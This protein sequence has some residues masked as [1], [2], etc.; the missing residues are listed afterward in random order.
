MQDTGSLLLDHVDMRLVT[1]DLGDASLDRNAIVQLDPEHPGFRDADY[2]ARRNR[3]A[4][5]ALEYEPGMPVP[6]APYTPE[7][8]EVWRTIWEA[9]E[10]AHRRHACAEYLECVTRLALPKGRIPQMS[11]V[12]EKVE[13]VSGF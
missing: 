8:H 11:E 6:E 3:I 10:P 13:A 9:L 4:E 7:E 1:T 5:I 2:R 12:S